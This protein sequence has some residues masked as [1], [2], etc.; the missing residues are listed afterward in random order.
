VSVTLEETRDNSLL[1]AIIALAENASSETLM[2]PA[3]DGPLHSY[4]W[5][6]EGKRLQNE[7]EEHRRG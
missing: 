2:H 6:R 1:R 4:I 5:S 3:F 7:L